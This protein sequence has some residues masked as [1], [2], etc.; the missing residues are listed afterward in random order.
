MGEGSTWV[1]RV[2]GLAFLSVSRRRASCDGGAP[3]QAMPLT[4]IV[5]R[6]QI[7]VTAWSLPR[8]GG[9]MSVVVIIGG[10]QV[11]VFGCGLSRA[12]QRAGGGAAGTDRKSTRLNS[13]HSQISY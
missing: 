6:A 8:R 1:K 12:R 10:F 7:C 5:N 2:L 11:A 3:A 9:R 4:S 13:S